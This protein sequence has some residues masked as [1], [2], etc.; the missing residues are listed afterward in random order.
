MILLIVAEHR[1]HL[2]YFFFSLREAGESETC[3]GI[4]VERFMKQLAMETLRFF[5]AQE[6]YTFTPEAKVPGNLILKGTMHTDLGAEKNKQRHFFLA[7]K[8]THPLKR[9]A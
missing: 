9:R 6:I 7:K 4:Q 1:E 2:D 5:G 8:H 3:G